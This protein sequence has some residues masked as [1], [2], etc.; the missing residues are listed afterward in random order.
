MNAWDAGTSSQCAGAGLVGV[1]GA[2]LVQL[3]PAMPS[4]PTVRSGSSAL[5]GMNTLPPLFS[6][7]STPWSKNW[8][9]NVNTELYGGESPVSVVTFGMNR[10][11]C[12][13]VQ[14]TG[15]PSVGGT[16]SGFGSVVHGTAV[17]LPP[18][19]VRCGCPAAATAAGFVL[20]WS[21]I[22]LLA[23][24]TSESM[25]DPVFCL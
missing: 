24:R 19:C 17:A 7:W 18:L 12:D 3:V 20:V 21:S 15:T 8:P 25:T 2:T 10:V 9:K 14:P 22:R 11:W 4:G 5:S 16:A 13:G 6:V 1:N 23:T